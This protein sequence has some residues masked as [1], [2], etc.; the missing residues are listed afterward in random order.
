MYKQAFK[1]QIKLKTTFR[2]KKKK[3]DPKWGRGGCL[4]VASGSKGEG[5]MFNEIFFSFCHFVFTVI[6]YQFDV[7]SK[8]LKKLKRHSCIILIWIK[9]CSMCCRATPHFLQEYIHRNINVQ[10]SDPT[11]RSLETSQPGK[12]SESLQRTDRRL[13]LSNTERLLATHPVG[14]EY[15]LIGSKLPLPQC[16]G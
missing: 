15:R 3:W 6:V 4:K 9:I 2:F 7:S 11:W 10:I 16:R 5:W 12:V 13:L 14:C 1:I 8:T